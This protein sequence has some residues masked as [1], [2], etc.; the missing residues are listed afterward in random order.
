MVFVQGV[1]SMAR[2]QTL[3]I[4][5]WMQL[6]RNARQI[7]QQRRAA[8]LQ[9]I[10]SQEEI[11]ITVCGPDRAVKKFDAL[12][13][14]ADEAKVGKSDKNQLHADCEMGENFLGENTK[15]KKKNPRPN[16]HLK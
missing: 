8:A 7:S 2:H 13:T 11:I 15:G 3:L 1:G 6:G 12:L 14:I 16:V 10:S 4:T 9:E 5:Q